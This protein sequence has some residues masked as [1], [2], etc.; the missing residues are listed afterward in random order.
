MEPTCF[1]LAQ[2]LHGIKLSRG[3]VNTLAPVVHIR[4]RSINTLVISCPDKRRKK[5]E[6]VKAAPSAAQ[7]SIVP[8]AVGAA[9]WCGEGQRCALCAPQ[10][11]QSAAD[12]A[13]TLRTW[14]AGIRSRVWSPSGTSMTR[15]WLC[16]PRTST[17]PADSASSTRCK[18]SKGTSPDTRKGADP[19][20]YLQQVS[21]EGGQ[22]AP[23]RS[24]EG[25]LVLLQHDSVVV[26]F[27]NARAH[28]LSV[29]NQKISTSAW[30][31]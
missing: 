9:W 6:K 12:G 20:L 30:P 10:D 17:A 16:P 23:Q 18:R 31:A 27:A 26:L 25:C 22:T 7:V 24:G 11:T 3:S 5:G 2:N 29:T 19:P 13:F 8:L 14:R 4:V 28:R 1:K 15:R 21:A